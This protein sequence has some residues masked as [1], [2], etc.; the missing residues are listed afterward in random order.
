MSMHQVLDTIRTFHGVLVLSPAA[1]SEFP[2]PAWGDHFFY[3]SPDGT[4]PQNI[5]PYGTIITKN[6]PEDAGSRLDTGG[7]WRLNIQLT[8]AAYAELLGADGQDRSAWH[9]ARTDVFLPHPLY[10]AQSWVAVVNPGDR[11]LPTAL[12]LLE[13]AHQSAKRRTERRT[14]RRAQPS[15]GAA[16]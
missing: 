13:E 12:Q 5:Q 10:A 6:Y 7:R 15:G 1:G 2:Q 11:T 8:R 4:I 3:Y 9:F 16:S 14:A